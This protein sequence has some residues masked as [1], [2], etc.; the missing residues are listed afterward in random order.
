MSENR[1]FLLRNRTQ[2]CSVIKRSVFGR[3]GLENLAEMVWFSDVP[4][5]PN[6]TKSFQFQ[7]VSEIRTICSVW[8]Y[9]EGQTQ[10]LKSELF[11]NGTKSKNAE[12]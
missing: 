7:T 2:K 4:Y 8:A 5:G 1:T 3:S 11:D 12:I 9:Y 6:Q 10:C